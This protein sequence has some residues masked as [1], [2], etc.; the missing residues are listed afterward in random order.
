MCLAS[1]GGTEEGPNLERKYRS[2][3]S[4]SQGGFSSNPLSPVD[5]QTVFTFDESKTIMAR[6]Q[7]LEDVYLKRKERMEKLRGQS[8]SNDEISAKIMGCPSQNIPLEP[9]CLLKRSNTTGIRRRKTIMH[10]TSSLYN[11]NSNDNSSS[12]KSHFSLTKLSTS[13]N[14]TE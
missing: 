11:S 13:S 8:G 14:I 1:S 12:P 7:W 9:D 4:G 5:R 6:P 3:S 2:S 10:R